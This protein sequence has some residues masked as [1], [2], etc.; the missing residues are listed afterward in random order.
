PSQYFKDKMAAWQK[1]FGEWQTKQK[2]F[3]AAGAKKTG[4]SSEAAKDISSVEDVSDIGGG[5][6]L[7]A[8]F[9]PEDWALIQLRHELYLL[10]D[11]FQKDANDPDRAGI[12]ENHLSFYYNKYFKKQLNPKLFN[13]ST[14]LEL[15]ALVKDTVAI[16]ADTQ[17]LTAPAELDSLGTFVKQTEE[18][19]RERQ[20]RID[21][22][23]ETARLKFVT[24]PA[25]VIAPV[26][27]LA[28]VASKGKGKGKW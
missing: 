16:A 24:V 21:A 5:E 26:K 11:A 1:Q 28:P 22:G 27:S 20:R 2:A 15:I 4:E 8:N 25:A 17:V 6:P 19:R 18:N 10:Q 13:L 7:F 12:P 3:K 23:D 9:A 14:N